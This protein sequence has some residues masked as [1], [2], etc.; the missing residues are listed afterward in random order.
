MRR[1]VTAS[2][3]AKS[4]FD[5]W[6]GASTNE[7]VFGTCS[8]PRTSRRH[9]SRAKP[10][11]RPGAGGERWREERAGL[12]DVLEAADLEAPPQPGQAEQEAAHRVVGDGL[13]ER[14]SE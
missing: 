3:R 1:R 5:R 11:R 14:R 8:R 9:H 13:L 10:S 6:T 12:R 2:T 4:A 7:P